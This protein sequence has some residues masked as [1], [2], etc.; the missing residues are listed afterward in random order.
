[1]ASKIKCS[2]PNLQLKIPWLLLCIVKHCNS[3]NL[4][5]ILVVKLH[6][7]A[8]LSSNTKEYITLST[9]NPC[10][11]WAAV[12]STSR[13]IPLIHHMRQ[14]LCLKF[15]NGWR[16]KWHSWSIVWNILLERSRACERNRLFVNTNVS[17][18]RN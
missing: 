18:T 3:T 5:Y 7:T 17:L 6:K 12:I 16:W 13:S 4:Q 9:P 10:F 1:M 14:M 15:M 11:Y 2:V 8:S